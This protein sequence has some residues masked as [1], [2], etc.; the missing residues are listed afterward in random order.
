M[1]EDLDPYFAIAAALG[2]FMVLWFLSAMHSRETVKRDLRNRG[3]VPLRIWWIPFGFWASHWWSI[4][5]RVSYLDL[6][7]RK[8]RA[9]CSVHPDLF[10]PPLSGLEVAWTKDEVAD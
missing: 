10:K 5:F 8:H 2:I 6:E 3:C 4:P 9:Y 1:S 7:G